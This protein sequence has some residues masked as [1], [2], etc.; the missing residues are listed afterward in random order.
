MLNLQFSL[1][2][3]FN[4]V[5]YF[6]RLQAGPVG[7]LQ[8]DNDCRGQGYGSL[9]CRAISRKI[10]EAGDDVYAG[11]FEANTRSRRMFESCGFKMVDT[12]HWLQINP[13]V[14]FEWKEEFD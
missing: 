7:V 4:Y 13:T 11:V 12:A 10:G 8:V 3:L 14:P 9:V 1:E 2:N 5:V 6:V